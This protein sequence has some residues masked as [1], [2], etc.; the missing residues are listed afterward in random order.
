MYNT[1]LHRCT[2]SIS[3][4]DVQGTPKEWHASRAHMHATKTQ[5]TDHYHES[6][7]LTRG[8]RTEGLQKKETSA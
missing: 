3:V 6:C 4:C 5:P 8:I 1:G 7:T 2:Y